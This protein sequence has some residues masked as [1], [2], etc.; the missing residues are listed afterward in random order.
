MDIPDPVDESEVAEMKQLY[1]YGPERAC[2]DR[3]I[4][5]EVEHAKM[6]DENDFLQAE[7]EANNVAVGARDKLAQAAVTIAELKEAVEALKELA[8]MARTTEQLD[9]VH[10]LN[11]RGL[12]K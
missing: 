5:L 7:L 10:Q 1:D 11:C 9:F 4:W 8:K 2:L 12:L 3:M 6:S